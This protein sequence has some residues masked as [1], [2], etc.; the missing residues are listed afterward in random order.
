MT[1]KGMRSVLIGALVG[2]LC[3]G[4]AGLGMAQSAGQATSPR[5]AEEGYDGWTFDLGL[6]SWLTALSGNV[7]ARGRDAKIDVT[8]DDALHLL[9]EL[10]FTIY[11]HTEVKKGPFG[12]IMDAYYLNLQDQSGL[13]FAV[14]VLVPPIGTVNIPVKARLD[15]LSETA[16]IEGA[17]AYDVLTSSE[18]SGGWPIWRLEA[19]AGA[20][21]TYLR[22]RIDADLTG[23]RGRTIGLTL[24][25]SRD[26]VDP[27]VGGRFSWRPAEG[28]L[29]GLRT[30][31][32]GFTV[33]SDFAWNVEATVSYKLAGWLSLDA[34]FRAL[35]AD[36][37]QGSFN[38]DVWT[39]GPW[40]GLGVKF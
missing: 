2:P 4:M 17:L 27:L 8:L 14:P 7:S 20:R 25:G 30:D 5:G 3:V 31:F 18:W 32:G 1:R 38:Y 26:W 10:Q 36:Y 28:W 9:D 19:L 34:G 23:P 24:D 40:A 39:Y 33:G 21:Y 11:G 35:Y 16:F 6:R 37:E 12:L 29:L 13:S 22:A 15:V